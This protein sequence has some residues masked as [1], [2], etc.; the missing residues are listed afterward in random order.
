MFFPF[1]S[2]SYSQ[3]NI[4]PNPGYEDTIHCPLGY[5]DLSAVNFWYSPNQ[6]SPDYFHA[7]NTGGVGVPNND[8]GY[9][10]A[11][12]GN[13]YAGWAVSFDS[14]DLNAREYLQVQLTSALTAGKKYIVTAYLAKADSVP[15]VLKEIGIALSISP[16]GNT[17]GTTINFTPQILYSQFVTD[18]VIWT[19][20]SQSIIAVG[21]EKYLTI[22]YFKDNNTSDSMSIFQGSINYRNQ[23]Y[24][25]VDDVSVIEDTST[26]IN[27]IPL[28]QGVK[29][30]SNNGIVSISGNIPTEMKIE[31]YDILGQ[32]IS[33]KI[34]FPFSSCFIN[35]SKQS[36]GLFF[37]KLNSNSKVII[38]KIFIFQ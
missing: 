13:G 11:R 24:Y 31:I 14:I 17:T 37:L 27:E 19:E 32:L 10:S 7:C 3:I 4:V 16:I 15:L 30:N 28:E 34:I 36:N 38:K 21:G 2:Y 8:F 25:Y 5:G 33:N 26:G 1:Y 35:L 18:T 23:A 22:G 29:I 20:I 9:Q 12:T 6:G